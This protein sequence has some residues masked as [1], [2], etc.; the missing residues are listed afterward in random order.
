[1]FSASLI[2]LSGIWR[3]GLLFHLC[4]SEH[5]YPHWYWS[6]WTPFYHLSEWHTPEYI[7]FVPRDENYTV[8]PSLE[9]LSRFS[10]GESALSSAIYP[11]ILRPVQYFY[12]YRDLIEN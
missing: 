8:L 6:I 4:Y 2:P 9:T 1:M 10:Y 3:D 5:S 11:R 12:V 7:V